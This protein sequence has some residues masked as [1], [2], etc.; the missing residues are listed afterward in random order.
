MTCWQVE[1]TTN[2]K[3]KER[4]RKSTCSSQVSDV[5][6]RVKRE[7]TEE[8]KELCPQFLHPTAPSY[9]HIS[10]TSWGFCSQIQ[11]K[12]MSESTGFSY[13]IRGLVCSP[14]GGEGEGAGPPP[15]PALPPPSL[16]PCPFPHLGHGSLATNQCKQL[17]YHWSFG[18]YKNF[19]VRPKHVRTQ[20]FHDVPK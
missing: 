3:R 18:H 16:H 15:S 2:S 1:L 7:G 5:L 8:E 17:W 13:G 19:T 10:T 20:S 4:Q 14:K 9:S 11:F 12:I 6:C